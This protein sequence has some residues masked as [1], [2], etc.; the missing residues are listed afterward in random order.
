MAVIA[1]AASIVAAVISAWRSASAEQAVRESTERT[2]RLE[3]Q[4]QVDLERI[5]ADFA[6]ALERTRRRLDA[7]ELL[8]QYREP[9]AGAAFDLRLR[10]RNI[11]AGNFLQAYASAQS[12]R[13]QEAIESTLFRVAQFFGWREA[14]RQGIQFLD[15]A[16]TEK[17]R[18]VSRLIAEV[19]I[20][21]ASD[22]RYG[23]A[24]MI[25]QEAQRAIGELMLVQEGDG[26][27]VKGFAAFQRAL[28][29]F[30][31][32]LR[33]IREVIESGQ[34][35]A[36]ARLASVGQLLGELVGHL[37]PDGKRFFDRHSDSALGR[38]RK[39]PGTE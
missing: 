20:A 3:R 30:E 26:I 8:A 7:D 23:Q 35:P 12:E 9:L 28:P 6:A 24:A 39:Q 37:D 1:A 15:F 16:E 31:P 22:H 10:L 29:E 18:E 2:A 19:T 21:W 13:R 34:A 11:T 36:S 5:R 4:N 17:S 38:E 33:P 32:Y 14:I 27:T 25:W